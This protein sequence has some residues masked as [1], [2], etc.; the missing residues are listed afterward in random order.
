MIT[1]I[2]I[3]EHPPLIGSSQS[4]GWNDILFA[5]SPLHTKKVVARCYHLYLL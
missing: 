5:G 3:Y 4:V 1:S 2:E